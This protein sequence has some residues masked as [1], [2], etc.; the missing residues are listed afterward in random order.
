MKIFSRG[1]VANYT[2]RTDFCQEENAGK[3]MKIFSNFSE[4]FSV[5]LHLGIFSQILGF[6]KRK[7]Q[8]IFILCTR[9]TAYSPKN[10][11]ILGEKGVN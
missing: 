7:T 9:K 8:Q 6:V 10:N 2:T 5:R 11:P 3:F 4:N 1:R